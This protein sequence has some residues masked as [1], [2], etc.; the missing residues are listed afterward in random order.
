[1]MVGTKAISTLSTGYLNALDY[2]KT[3]IQG[4]DLTQMTDKTA[5]RVSILHHPDVRR[6]LMTQKAYAEGLRALYLYTAAHQDVAAA[7]IVSGADAGMAEPRQRPAAADRQGRRV[8]TGLPDADRVAADLRRFG[9][10]AGL[11]DRAVHP[12]RQDRLAVR[13]HHGDPGAGLLLPQDRPRPGRR[14]RARRRADPGVPRRR[15]GAARTR[16]L[17][18]AAGHRAGRRAGDGRHHDRLSDCLATE[19]PRPVPGGPGLGLVPA[20]R[21]RPLHRMDAAAAAP[22]SPWT[23]STA[24]P[25]NA[26]ARSTAGRSPR[27]GS[28]PRTCCRGSVPNA[29]SSN[30]STWPRW[31]STKEPSNAVSHYK[32]NVRDLAF[33]LFEV[34][35]PRK[36]PQ[37]VA[38]SA[39]WRSTTSAACWTRPR[40]RQRVHWPRHSRRATATR[41]RSTRRRTR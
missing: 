2:A 3:R 4:A 33:N 12:R 21:R 23:H 7:D 6:A 18:R 38:S 41:R 30:R 28:S 16:R 13:G 8:R 40:A 17:P 11:S 39:V 29:R 10:P 32:A 37:P 36:G 26:T 19:L 22:R 34:L 27:Q 20:G 15:V 25:P 31:T 5:P 24:S 9:L 14:A 1:M 35:G